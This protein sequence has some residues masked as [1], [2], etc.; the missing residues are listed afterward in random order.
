M[1]G[2]ASDGEASSFCDGSVR[3]DELSSWY[4]YYYCNQWA[5]IDDWMVKQRTGKHH[6]SFCDSTVQFGS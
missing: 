5:R 1:D 3:D 4:Y 2:V 6:R